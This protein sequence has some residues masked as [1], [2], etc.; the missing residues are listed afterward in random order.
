MIEKRAYLLDVSVRK[1][2][3]SFLRRLIDRLALLRY[4]ELLL[5]STISPSPLASTSNPPFSNSNPPFSNSNSSLQLLSNWANLKGISLRALNPQEL[6]SLR[7]EGV[8][9][10][11]TQASG[12]L[13]GRV[14]EMRER[15]GKAEEYG[16]EKG[17]RRFLVTDFSDGFDW[18]SPI[19]SLPGMVLGGYFASMGAKAAKIDLEREVSQFLDAPLAGSLLRLGTLYLRGGAYRDEASEFFNILSHDVGYSR[20]PGVT[21]H[22]LEEVSTILRGIMSEAE[23]YLAR[24]ES[25]KDV[26]Y[27]ALLLDAACHR[28]SEARL[29]TVK[30]ELVKMWNRHF[31]SSGREDAALKIPRF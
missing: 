17:F 6:E 16:R 24:S 9:E 5:F 12:S 28:R 2:T 8:A 29:R 13:A 4:N 10:A 25:A 26:L 19:V 31:E 30:E 7:A 14:E 15:M 1:P 20:H 11:S 22:V 27:S 21:D 23:R 18:H 3:E